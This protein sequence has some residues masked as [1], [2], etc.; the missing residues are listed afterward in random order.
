MEISE[1]FR[2]DN[3]VWKVWKQKIVY[4]ED[5]RKHKL[6]AQ[7]AIYFPNQTV[8]ASMSWSPSLNELSEFD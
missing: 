4:V 6:E 8:F 1:K 7:V 3:N 5:F 2:L